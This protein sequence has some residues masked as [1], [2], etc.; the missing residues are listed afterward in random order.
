MP[1]RYLSLPTFILFLLFSCLSVTGALAQADAHPVREDVHVA[2][3]YEPLAPDAAMAG[4]EVFFAPSAGCAFETCGFKL[5]GQIKLLREKALR[6]RQPESICVPCREQGQPV[7][8]RV[9][10]VPRDPDLRR[11]RKRVL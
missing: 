9:I 4:H 10:A 5:N 1:G 7:L 2:V 8:A 11:F 6:T 3:S